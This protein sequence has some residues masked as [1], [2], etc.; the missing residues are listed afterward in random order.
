MD[1]EGLRNDNN[2]KIT[3]SRIHEYLRDPF[4]IGINVWLGIKHPGK[5]LPL[6]DEP[7]FKKVQAVLKGKST[8]KLTK[9]DY[10]FKGLIY[11]EECGGLITWEPP[12]KGHFYGHCNHYRDCT[13]KVWA[14]KEDVERQ[15][16]EYLNKL[17]VKSPRLSEWIKKALKES[18]KEEINYHSASVGEINK[19][20][21]LIKSRLD[22]LYIDK[23]DGKITEENY[24][25]FYNE[26]SEALR[27]T[28]KS[29]NRHTNATLKYF[30]LGINLYELSQNAVA[31]YNKAEQDQKR[32]LIHLVF[33]RLTLNEKKLT[34]KYTR[35]FQILHDAV[36][37][38]N[39]TKIE[40]VDEKT[41]KIFVPL[42][43]PVVT[44]QTGNS[45]TLRPIWLP[46][47]D[48]NLGHPPYSLPKVSSG[49]GTISFPFWRL[50]KSQK[51][52]LGT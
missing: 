6:I 41:D 12:K 37:A 36:V 30:E 34:V 7:L 46:R 9:H 45:R 11:C 2:N 33:E 31:I 52:G 3:K 17:E 14:E 43:K 32:A 50:R 16:C 19:Q 29:L 5:Q 49:R 15:L 8:L 23:L 40:N 1:K 25:R 48:S 21:D 13:R 35:A 28:D 18:H 51:K 44:Q 39:G 10:M 20:H 38:T 47:Q 4:Y 22:K 42:K 24:Q 27:N 26:F